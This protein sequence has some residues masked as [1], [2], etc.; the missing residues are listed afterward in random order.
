M[1]LRF[2]ILEADC[3]QQQ[4]HKICQ[5]SSAS[6]KIVLD[7]SQTTFMDSSG[8]IALCKIVRE[9]RNSRVNLVFSSFSPQVQMVLSLAGLDEVIKVEGDRKALDR[10]HHQTT[11]RHIA[12][13]PSVM[14]KTKR[15][16]DI[17]GALVGLGTTAILFIPLVIAIIFCRKS[18]E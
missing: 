11:S 1:P 17:L 16:I 4:F 6:K 13:H 10:V 14:S 9:A 7:F 3:F 5:T 18:I 8:L 2:T 15:L 12:I